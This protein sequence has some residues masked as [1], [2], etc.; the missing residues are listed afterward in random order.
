MKIEKLKEQIN[1]FKKTEKE[2][3]DLIAIELQCAN[4]ALDRAHALSEKYGVPFGVSMPGGYVHIPDS[5][6]EMMEEVNSIA[7][8]SWDENPD[9]EVDKGLTA[10][11]AEYID[12]LFYEDCG[13]YWE[14]SSYC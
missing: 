8:N 9:K 14:A 12:D 10:L 11:F 2:G 13:E 5:F 7:S 3:V 4:D 6:R 1:E